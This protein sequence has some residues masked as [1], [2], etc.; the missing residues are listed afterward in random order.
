MPDEI[1]RKE[2][3]LQVAVAP[4]RN[5]SGYPD[6][7]KPNGIKEQAESRTDAVFDINIVRHATNSRVHHFIESHQDAYNRNRQWQ[8]ELISC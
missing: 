5:Q 1:K 3:H 7:W 4:K 8:E 2:E 6:N